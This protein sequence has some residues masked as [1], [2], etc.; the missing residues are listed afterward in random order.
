MKAHVP[1]LR[2]V[3]M[4]P[5]CGHWAQQERPSEVNQELIEFLAALELSDP[6]AA[7]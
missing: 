3:V 4:L 1:G 2:K 7:E 6:L 5:G